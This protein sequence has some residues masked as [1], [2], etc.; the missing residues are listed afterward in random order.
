MTKTR[1]AQERGF[2]VALLISLLVS[3]SAAL[4][5]ELLNVEPIEVPGAFYAVATKINNSGAVVGTYYNPQGAP[6]GGFLRDGRGNYT[7]VSIA[8]GG[9]DGIYVSGV[10]D[11]GDLVGRYND[12]TGW[13]G[14]KLDASGYPE[15]IDVPGGSN[16]Q[17]ADINNY[18]TLVGHFE[19]PTGFRGFVRDNKGGY[20]TLDPPGLQGAGSK[21]AFAT[22]INDHGEIV[23]FF[24]DMNGEHGFLR[25]SAGNYTTLD[26][27]NQ[28]VTQAFGINNRG[29][30]VG[31]FFDRWGGIPV[32]MHGFLRNK[33]GDYTILDVPGFIETRLLDINENG[34][35]IGLY[36][37]ES[38]LLHSFLVEGLQTVEAAISIKPGSHSKK[39]CL[40]SR[41]MVRVAIL[42]NDDFDAPAQ[43]DQ[44]S[45]TFGATGYEQS[46]A[47]CKRKPISADQ[48]D[49]KNDLVCQFQTDLAGFQCGDTVG[50]LRGVTKEGTSVRGS[51]SVSIVPCKK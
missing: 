25:D 17:V 7:T 43:I 5:V 34:T 40:R 18:D 38:G 50:V 10:N 31:F 39:I 30:I 26:I 49:L 36:R 13:H 14:F 24:Q 46:L 22:G 16:T 4:S 19:S 9:F 37:D 33:G 45:L 1:L 20:T 32:N 47:F 42:S 23:G 11:H 21:W 35:I 15:I 6:Q 8:G 3:P 51:D 12:S 29:E 27:L 41:K 28:N 48:G 44:S 2:I